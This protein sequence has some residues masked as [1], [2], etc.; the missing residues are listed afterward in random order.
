MRKFNLTFIALFGFGTL[1][2]VSAATVANAEELFRWREADGSLTYSPTPPPASSGIAYEKVSSKSGITAAPAKTAKAAEPL[3]VQTPAPATLPTAQ[4][5]LVAKT[6]QSITPDTK[7]GHCREL[8]KRVQS[9]E[10]LIMT[11]VSNEIMDNAVVQM[12]RYQ[13]SFNQSC[14]GLRMQGLAN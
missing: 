1:L 11:D 8:R 4:P 7:T 5:A 14:Q 12:A 3:Q 6:S 2:V 10:R 13:T 9:L